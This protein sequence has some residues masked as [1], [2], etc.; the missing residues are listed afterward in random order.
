MKENVATVFFLLVFINVRLLSGESPPGKPVIFKC[1]SPDKETFTCWWKPGSDGGHPTN[2]TLTY[3]KEG[4]NITYECPDYETSGPNSCYFSRKYTSMWKIYIIT[5]SA[6]NKLGTSVSNP[7]YVDVTDIVEPNT[8]QNLTLEIKQPEDR[9][10]Y[11]WIKWFPPTMADIKSGW[12]TLQYEI[13]LKTEKEA[14]WETHFAGQQT[15]FKILSFYPGYTYYVQVRCKSNHGYWSRWSQER[16]I[17]IPSDISLKDST[18]WIFVAIFS[19][20]ICLIML[21]AVT[22]KGYSIMSC[23]FP[24]VPGPKIKGFDTHLLEKGKSEELLSVFG[25]QDFPPTSDCED[26][27]VE[28][29]EVDDNEEQQLMPA[30]LKGYPG[31]DVKSR[32]LDPDNDSGR[33]SCDSPSLLSEKCEGSWANTLTFHTPDAIEKLEELEENSTCSWDAQSVNTDSKILRFHANG[34]KSSTWPSLPSGPHRLRSPYHSIANVCKPAVDPAGAPATL[35]DQVGKDAFRS[36]KTTETREEEKAAGQREMESLPSGTKQETAQLPLEEQAPLFSDK[37]LDYVQ[38]HKVNRD[39]ILLLIPKQKAGSHQMEKPG[40]PETNKEYTKVSGVVD[41]NI[42]VFMP[43]PQDQSVATLFEEP[44]KEDSPPLQ[45]NQT[46]KDTG[47]FTPTPSNCKLQQSGSD[48]LDPASF[49]HSFHGWL[50]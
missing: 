9:K 2:Y 38:I 10:P 23:I 22:I 50:D 46:E 40:A 26:L 8:P 6:T 1:R 30:F 24:P 29:L 27:L 35:L 20:V 7:C 19:A 25:C 45:H 33:G 5:V 37:P 41:N 34:S 21:W 28:F 32:P 13:R 39:G 48:Y 43:D 14:E 12:L 16:S 47:C 44:A 42:L 4:D 18:A 11:L 3:Y 17:Q 49:T 36:S 31:Q 15:H